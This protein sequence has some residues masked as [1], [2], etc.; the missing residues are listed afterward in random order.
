MYYTVE[1]DNTKKIFKERCNQIFKCILQIKNAT[2]KR[3]N[4]NL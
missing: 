2:K 3:N 1:N 4:N